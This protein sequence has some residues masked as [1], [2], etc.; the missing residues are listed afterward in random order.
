MLRNWPTSLRSRLIVWYLG[1]FAALLAGLCTVQ[2][3]TLSGYLSS[4]TATNM[5][6]TVQ[7]EL[8]L[9]RTCSIHSPAELRRD[10]LALA[11][12]LG[13]DEMAA[14]IVTPAGQTL[15]DRGLGPPGAGH[16]LQLSGARIRQLT[17]SAAP[18]GARPLSCPRPSTAFRYVPP[19]HAV[20]P[21][22]VRN[23]D[24]LFITIPLGPQPHP[25]GY[26]ILARSLA[27]ENAFLLRSRLTLWLGALAV[28]I[29]AAVVAL[30]IINRALRPLCRVTRTAETIAAGNFDRRA[31]LT[32]SIDEIG[33]LGAAFDTMVDRLHAALTTVTGSE[34]RMRQFLADASHELR[35]PLTVLRGTSQ[36]LL[37]QRDLDEGEAT[38][39]L[40][41]IN[42]EATRLSRLVDDLLTLS[43]L[44]AG[45]PLDPYPV[46]LSR[47]LINFV[48]RYAP[49]WPSRT[50]GVDVAELDDT[51]AY[52]DPEALRR[53]LTNVVDNAARY[54][55]A[56]R[57]ITISAGADT[58]RVSILVRDEGPGLSAEE[59]QRVFERFYRGNANRSHLSGGSGLGLAI[60]RALVQQSDGEIQID[61]GPDRGTTVAIT[62]PRL[63]QPS[64]STLH[65]R[66]LTLQLDTIS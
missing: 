20:F 25:V 30:P 48:Q 11:Q 2:T 57:P 13:S 14:K 53:V 1:V 23:G 28:F 52:V 38:A 34:E 47:F 8:A 55:A 59:A 43:R 29:L 7:S 6:Q 51:Q 56:G 46:T 10:A 63:A 18:S 61:T 16:P 58:S 3:V 42:D 35:T 24:L 32:G 36:I 12:F 62:L 5:G 37:R 41:A 4:T 45:Q 19:N 40:S 33:R 26:A 22:A 66:D 60:V 27:T 9:V 31:N 64:H 50:I 39:A 54:S 49:A 15:A 17:T 21:H 44:D 65:L